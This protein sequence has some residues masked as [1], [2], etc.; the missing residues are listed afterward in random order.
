M[1]PIPI[2]TYGDDRSTLAR[3]RFATSSATFG[4]SSF[5]LIAFWPLLMNPA[6]ASATPQDNSRADGLFI[7]YS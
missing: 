2:I 6:C 1:P 7:L 4:L 5:S 3:I